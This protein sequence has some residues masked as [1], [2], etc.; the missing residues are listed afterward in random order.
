[1][2]DLNTKAQNT[3]C[4]GCPNFGILASF[5]AAVGE[6]VSA[7]EL[8]P[9]NIVYTAGIGCHGKI[10]DY[11][12]LNSFISLHGRGVSTLVGVKIANPALKAVAFVGDGDAYAEG[13]EHL[14][15]AAK[16]NTDITVIVH[17]NQVF[18]LTTGQFTPVSPKGYKGRSTPY[19]S[20][21][22][23]FNPL[24][25]LIAS[26]AT[27]VAR[28]YALEPQKTKAILAA[29]L[30]HKG[31]SFVEIIQPCITFYDTREDIKKRMYWLEENYPLNN[32]EWA[33]EKLNAGER[34][35]MGIFYRINKPVFED[36]LYTLDSPSADKL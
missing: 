17:N 26:G 9:E 14:L 11:I 8:K 10:G 21:E 22:E 31:F 1:M 6:L 30:R 27:F 2:L 19:G 16:R 23:P 28:S 18:A 34:L 4:P 25:L 35:P 13:L 3:W 5:K 20:L 15:H 32:T 33:R 36:E 29:A 7:G 12:N 24:S